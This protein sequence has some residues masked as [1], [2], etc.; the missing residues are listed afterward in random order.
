MDA[1]EWLVVNALPGMGALRIAQ[2]LARQP[3]W[4]AGWLAALPSRA[5]SELRLWLEQPAR[6]PLQNVIDETLAWQQSAPS[7][8]ILHRDHPAWPALLNELPDPPVVLWAQGDLGALE[9]PKLAMVGTRRPTGEGTHNAQAFARDLARRGWCVVSGMALGIDGVA[10]RAAL[11]AGGSTIAV[12]GCGVDVIYPASHRDLHEQLSRLPGGL[13]LSEH[14]PGTVARPAFFPR[15]NRIVT[16]LSLGTLVVEATEKS[17]SLVSARLTLEQ[18]RELFVLPGSLHN[19]QAR[20]CLALLRQGSAHLAC[21]VDDIIADLGH[22]A[23]A[24]IPP[25]DDTKQGVS[26]GVERPS[27]QEPLPE[28]LPETLPDD[29][30]TSLSATPT[31]IDLLVHATGVT[32]SDCQQRLLMLELDGWVSQQAGGW[33]RLP[34]P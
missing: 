8:H 32:V 34:R 17:G 28:S 33:V 22:W 10:Q 14:P 5:A 29:L 6:S 18:N 1:H 20:G 4:P 11:N 9:G 19:V 25:D 24:F 12:L 31:P 13:V 7:R 26:A 2:L 16:G 23:E 15:R 30:L 21:S 27:N 3:Q